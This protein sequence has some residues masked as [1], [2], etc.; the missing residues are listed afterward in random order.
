MLVAIPET[1]SPVPYWISAADLEGQN[2]NDGGLP[3]LVVGY[4]S[5]SDSNAIDVFYNGCR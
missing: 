2:A 3:D 1:T 5:G 4:L